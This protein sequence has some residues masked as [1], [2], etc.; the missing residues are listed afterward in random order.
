MI[1]PRRGL[2]NTSLSKRLGSKCVNIQDLLNRDYGGYSARPMHAPVSMSGCP[3]TRPAENVSLQ[4]VRVE[5]VNDQ[6]GCITFIR[7]KTNEPL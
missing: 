1:V 2:P 5:N 6:K 7:L 3:Q 4:I